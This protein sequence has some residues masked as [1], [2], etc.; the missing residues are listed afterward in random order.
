MRMD[1]GVHD[2]SGSKK[3]RGE[4]AA[5]EAGELIRADEPA[6]ARNAPALAKA[7]G[8]GVRRSGRGR[9]RM[10]VGC[11]ASGVGMPPEDIVLRDPQI[12]AS[13]LV[14]L[15]EVEGNSQ[16]VAQPQRQGRQRLADHQGV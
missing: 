8:N 15:L 7:A 5:T 4:I 3:R 12:A 14:A 13:L 16:V 6:T 10:R 2:S 11:R 1:D 9:R